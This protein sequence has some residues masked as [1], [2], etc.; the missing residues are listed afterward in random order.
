MFV[1]LTVPPIAVQADD[2]VVGEWDLCGVCGS[3]APLAV[4]IV[5]I[6]DLCSDAC[7]ITVMLEEENVDHDGDGKSN[8]CDLDDRPTTTMA[9]TCVYGAQ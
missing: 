5:S 2:D 7:F 3:L 9:A 4:P 6:I 8:S 1:F